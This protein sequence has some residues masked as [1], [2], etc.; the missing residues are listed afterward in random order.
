MSVIAG[1]IALGL[2]VFCWAGN[3]AG[4][5]RQAG[6]QVREDVTVA[7]KLLQ[8]YVTTKDG[9]P[10]TDLTA[11]DFEVTDN[12]KVVPVTHFENHILGG[13]DIAPG[14]PVEGPRINRK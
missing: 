1:A 9:K 8:A 3:G 10:V 14:A 13:D 4:A 11:A 7:L 5:P 2:V 6:S 12:G